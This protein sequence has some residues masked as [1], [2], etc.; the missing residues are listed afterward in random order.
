MAMQL[1]ST[2]SSECESLR[3]D[4]ALSLGLGALVCIPLC[5][6][7]STQRSRLYLVGVALFIWTLLLVVWSTPLTRL[8]STDQTATKCSVCSEMVSEIRLRSPDLSAVANT[9]DT[10]RLFRDATTMLSLWIVPVGDY[11]DEAT[12][13]VGFSF[14]QGPAA[15]GTPTPGGTNRALAWSVARLLDDYAAA[16]KAPPQVMVQWEIAQALLEEHGIRADVSATVDAQGHYLSTY[17]V[18]EQLAVALGQASI[19]T[20]VLVAHPDHAVRCGKVVQHFNITALGTQ[21]LR[22]PGGIPWVD[23]GCDADGY[24]PM[25]TQPWTTARARYLLHELRSRPAMVIAGEVDFSNDNFRA[26]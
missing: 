23:F 26:A 15:N 24:D 11:L 22:A 5:W 17:G 14:A 6:R 13:I 20:V 21:M 18:M 16:G 12:A 4:S 19:R 3:R 1:S 25:S 10:E 7:T 2:S 8:T 9:P